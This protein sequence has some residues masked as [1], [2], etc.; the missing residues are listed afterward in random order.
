MVAESTQH[1]GWTTPPESTPTHPPP[2]FTF[3]TDLSL[4]EF[5]IPMRDYLATHPQYDAI[6]TGCLVFWLSPLGI[7]HLLVQKRSAHDSMPGRWEIPGGGCDHED[8]SILHGA[9]RELWEESGL[10]AAAV[11]GRVGGEHVFFSRRGMR[12]GKFNFEVEVEG[13]RGD[14]PPEVRLDA[15]EHEAYV[16]ATEEECR[17]GRKGETELRFT[18]KGQEDAIWAGFERRKGDV[19]AGGD[20]AEVGTVDGVAK[21]TVCQAAV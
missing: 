20:V 10:V 7:L 5:T 8:E 11:V 4:S 6:A 3:T 15:N 19:K 2:K 18:T 14:E 16:W 1:P 17:A 9:A 12:I 21:L 13:G